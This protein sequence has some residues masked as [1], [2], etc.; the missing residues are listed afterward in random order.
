[1]SVRASVRSCVRPCATTPTPRGNRLRIDK[2][3]SFFASFEKS[4]H[5]IV[6]QYIQ[7]DVIARDVSM[8]TML[9]YVTAF[10]HPYPQGTAETNRSF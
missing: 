2:F 8:E 7:C 10:H 5:T 9:T 4:K 1:M 3:E 6:L